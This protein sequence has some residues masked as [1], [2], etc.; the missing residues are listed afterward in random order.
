MIRDDLIVGIVA[1]AMS[2][3][4]FAI[5]HH[6]GREACNPIQV[7]EAVTWANDIDGESAPAKAAGE[8]L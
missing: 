8:A 7:S 3:I 1:A 4:L 5:G 6:A 2:V